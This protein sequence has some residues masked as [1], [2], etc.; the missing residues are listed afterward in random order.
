[1][2]NGSTTRRISWLVWFLVEESLLNLHIP[3]FYWV[4]GFCRSKVWLSGCSFW[5][6][7]VSLVMCDVD[8]VLEPV[9]GDFS[10]G[11]LWQLPGQG[12]PARFVPEESE[13][14]SGPQGEPLDG[15]IPPM[16][17]DYLCTRTRRILHTESTLEKRNVTLPK[18]NHHYCRYGY[19]IVWVIG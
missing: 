2:G 3:L 6:F 10:G 1:M 11:F 14:A 13:A 7:P 18:G 17:Y 9:S 4:L 15:W 5:K 16:I 19:C 12:A 8:G